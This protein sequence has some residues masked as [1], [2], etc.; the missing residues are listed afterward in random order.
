M[1]GDEAHRSRSG[2]GYRRAGTGPP[3]LLLHGIPGSGASWEPIASR[4]GAAVDVIVPDLL[5]FG[6]SDRPPGLAGLHARGQA[7][8]VDDLLDELGIGP[9]TV[10]G[11]DF[12]GPVA[13]SLVARRPGAVAAMGLLATNTF[14]DTP[15][16]F[17]LSAVNWPL[18]GPIARRA[19]FSP[20]SL[21]MM[22]RHGVGHGA[23]PPD[24]ATHLATPTSNGQSPRSSPEAS[25]AS[26]SCTVRSKRNSTLSTFQSSSD[27][28]T[29]IRSSPSRRASGRLRLPAASCACTRVP[30]TSCPMSAPTK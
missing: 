27:G 8:A 23:T 22:L 3:V 4:L 10:I 28:A 25:P 24:A 18:L 15:I 17:P 2:L 11:H 6:A 5:G 7:A 14:R 19:L 20:V 29:V 12:G 30:G 16:P 13:L 26:K 21:R 1:W 9:V